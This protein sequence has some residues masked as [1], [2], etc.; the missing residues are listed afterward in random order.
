MTL[1]EARTRTRLT[2]LA[3]FAKD[4]ALETLWPTRCAICDAPGSLI[5]LRCRQA[6]LLVDVN[7]ACPICGAPFGQHLCTECNETM[8]AAAERDALPLNGMASVLLADD[9]ARRVVTIYKDA[10]ERRLAEEMAEL[11]TRYVPPEWQDAHLTFIPATKEAVR[12]RG[13]DHAEQLANAVAARA[14]MPLKHVF[15]RPRN[16]DQRKFGRRERQRNMSERFDVLPGV[17]IPQK[18]VILDDICTTGATLFSAADCLRANGAQEVFGLTFAK[19][20]A[21]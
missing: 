21:T 10:N 19:V 5:C 17:R 1:I 18:V 20:L 8:L 3:A 9:A 15:A 13:F 6:L 4:A 12:R 11:M 16:L 7:H 2:R 14:K